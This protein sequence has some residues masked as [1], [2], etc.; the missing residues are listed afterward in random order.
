MNGLPP[1]TPSR[2][3]LLWE[4]RDEA[5]RLR[6]SL[7]SVDAFAKRQHGYGLRLS[8]EDEL[9]AVLALLAEIEVA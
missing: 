1:D 8:T 2:R 5:K 9:R 7:V 6:R 3:L 4:I